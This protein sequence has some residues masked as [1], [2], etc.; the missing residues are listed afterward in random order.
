M[1]EHMETAIL[2]APPPPSVVNL[3][4][5]LQEV[6][7]MTGVLPREIKGREKAA[8]ITWARHRFC[9]VASNTLRA[10][11]TPRYSLSQI[12]NF[13]GGRHHTTILHGKHKWQA[14]LD[15]PEAHPKATRR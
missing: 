13:L 15:E 8:R 9:W 6:S 11:G 3:T 2:T 7:R 14:F 10:D 1:S 4:T 12:G 5:I